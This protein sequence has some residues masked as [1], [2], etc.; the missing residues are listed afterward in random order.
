MNSR[1]RK[2]LCILVAAAAGTLFPLLPGASYDHTV[3][4]NLQKSRDAL[5]AQRT[6]L[7]HAHDEVEKQ[8][9]NLQTRQTRLDQYLRQVN[10]ALRD[11]DDALR[12]TR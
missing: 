8:I 6:D 9:D 2:M 11:V 10:S 1:Q 4:N 3:Y 5:I 12:G 7:E